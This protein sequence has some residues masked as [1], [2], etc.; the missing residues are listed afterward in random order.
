MADEQGKPQIQITL[1]GEFGAK[2]QEDQ[3]IDTNRLDPVRESR[4]YARHALAIPAR[5]EDIVLQSGTVVCATALVVSF[6]RVWPDPK[7]AG[8]VLFVA[9]VAGVVT[10]YHWQNHPELR[11]FINYWVLLIVIGGVLACV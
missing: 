4:N 11:G 3:K 10:N 9:M 7:L 2:K 1:P 6:L 5:W 8:A